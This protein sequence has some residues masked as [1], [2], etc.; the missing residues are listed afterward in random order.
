MTSDAVR[1]QMLDLVDRLAGLD[2]E[3]WDAQSLCSQWRVRDVLAH[4]TAGETGAFRVSRV[5]AGLLR[6]GFDYD[7]WL[8]VDGQTQGQQEPATILRSFRTAAANRKPA[9]GGREIRAL[10]HV[11]VHGQDICRLLSIRRDLPESQL[12]AIASYVATSIIFRAN[13]YV[14]GLTLTASDVEWT[15]GDGPEV[16]GSA[17]ALVM[18]MAGRRIVIDELTGE[19]LPRLQRTVGK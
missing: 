1:D 8:A 18:L 14:A 4:I 13:R 16:S 11:F 2:D 15:H 17:E 19:G 7:R 10:T 12:V 5:A 9:R 3:Q 6:H